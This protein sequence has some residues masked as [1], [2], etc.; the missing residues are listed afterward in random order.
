MNET[1]EEEEDNKEIADEL[2]ARHSDSES[3][4]EDEK[5]ILF[6]VVAS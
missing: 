6:V 4:D 3:E 2:N 1:P 5:D